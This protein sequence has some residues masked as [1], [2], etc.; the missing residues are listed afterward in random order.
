MSFQPYVLYKSFHHLNRRLR[1]PTF[2][3]HLDTFSAH[4]TSRVKKT[5][6]AA[7]LFVLLLLLFFL[8]ISHLVTSTTQVRVEMH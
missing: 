2:S 4:T 5:Y 1:Q 3:A 7:G 6:L 8:V